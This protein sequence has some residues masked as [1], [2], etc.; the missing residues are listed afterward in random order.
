MDYEKAYKEALERAR[1]FSDKPYL[2][3]SK[4]IVDY[5]FPELKEKEDEQHRKWI[6]EYLYD[7]LRKSDEQ[8]KDHFKA[9]I[10]WL[11]KQCE[12]KPI[13]KV[14]PKFRVGDEIKTSNEESLT[15][16]KIDEKGYWSEDLFI[17]GFDDADN[18]KLVEQKPADKI[19]PK[20]H[21]GDWIVHHGTENIYQVVAIIGNQYQL[22]YGDNYTVQKCTDV[23]R[24]AR[25]WNIT[26][27]AKDG[28]VLVL[29]DEVFI[30]AHRKQLYSIAVAHCFV[31][32]TGG[33]HFD[34]EFGH[35]E[36]GN[37]I[38]PATKEQRDL[39]F[40][41]MKEAGYEWDAE[42]KE[43]KKIE[44]KPAEW[45]KEDERNFDI[46]YGIIYNSCIA[47]DASRLNTWLLSLR[48]KKQWKPSDN[49]LEVL[50]LAAEKDGTCLMGL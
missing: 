23:D 9:A 6:L 5:I 30:Y 14:E 15:I 36:E 41:K 1:Q 42:K 29:N 12:Q 48:P 43:L 11:E 44:Q 3:D 13:D 31:D 20:F 25:L 47:E 35:T 7:G 39:L 38:H 22:K 26:K 32:S 8:F 50:R 40:K 45:S 17:C 24:C 16:T 27:D 2:E 33:F 37:S 18:W 19:E 21:K 46:I 49:E 34:G 10:A 28:D 4:G